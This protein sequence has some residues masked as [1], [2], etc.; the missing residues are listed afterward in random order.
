MQTIIDFHTHI[1]LNTA[2]DDRRMLHEEVEQVPLRRIV[3]CGLK[4]VNPDINTVRAIN[5]EVGIFLSECSVARGFVYLNPRHGVKAIDELKRCMDN[6]FVGIK[7][8]IATLADDA[9]NFPVYEAAIQYNLPVLLHSLDKTVKEYEHESRSN[10]VAEAARRY[11][12][13]TFIMAH[14]S[15][16]FIAGANAAKPYP[17]LYVDICGSFGE[18]GMVDYAVQT[19]GA[20]RVLFGSDMPTCADIYHNLGKVLAA[21]LTPEE[22]ELILWKNAEQILR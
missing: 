21:K 12:E 10:H 14:L 1:W 8:W 22:Q 20:E 18:R 16:K 2:Q 9:L 15:G 17:N 6:G 4:D 13:C 19:L 11:P 7:L 5:D 3:V